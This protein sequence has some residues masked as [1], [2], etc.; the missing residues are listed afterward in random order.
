[1]DSNILENPSDVNPDRCQHFL[2]SFKRKKKKISCRSWNVLFHRKWHP[3]TKTFPHTCCSTKSGQQLWQVARTELCL[4]PLDFSGEAVHAK[5]H[6]LLLLLPLVLNKSVW[7]HRNNISRGFPG[8][9]NH[10]VST[11]IQICLE[12]LVP[13]WRLPGK[14]GLHF[15]KK[16]LFLISPTFTVLHTELYHLTYTQH[17]DTLI[18]QLRYTMTTTSVK[19]QDRYQIILLLKT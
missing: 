1:M 18:Y 2:I 11:E 12:M 10:W 3:K 6:D 7:A 5:S 19:A 16:L 8:S 15:E 14:L 4:Y 17:K 13:N 9:V